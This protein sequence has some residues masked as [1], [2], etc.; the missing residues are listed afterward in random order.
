MF[1]VDHVGNRMGIVDEVTGSFIDAGID[2]Q[3][4][5]GPGKNRGWNCVA[6]II[7]RYRGDK[8]SVEFYLNGKS[9][10][11]S[12]LVVC[13][14]PIG[15]IGNSKSKSEPFGVVADLKIYPF[16]MAQKDE[17][18]RSQ[19]IYNK[20]LEFSMPDQHMVKFMQLPLFEHI[21]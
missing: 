8:Q 2:L 10:G 9:T 15:F 5:K 18:F 1:Q 11:E 17:L 13:T 16:A 12:K 14:E 6:M 19:M 7:R 3:S 20:K 21:V 4:S